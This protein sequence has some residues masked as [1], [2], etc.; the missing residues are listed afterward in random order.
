VNERGNDVLACTEQKQ[1]Q[2]KL[3]L[4][5]WSDFCAGQTK[6]LA[7][8]LSMLKRKRRW[9]Q[10]S[11]QILFDLVDAAAVPCIAQASQHVDNGIV[12]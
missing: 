2:P 12:S 11:L 9:S 1:H 3:E 6:P 4:T 8:L 10:F 5:Q 7:E